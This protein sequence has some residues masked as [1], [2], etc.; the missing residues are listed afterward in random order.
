MK[1]AQPYL[2]AMAVEKRQY[3][4]KPLPEIA[5]AG[6]SNVG[7][8][9]FL[10]KFVGRKKL[11]YT[12]SSPGKTQ[13]VNFYNIDEK[14]R[15]VDLPG[16]G[17]A[18]AS[19]KAQEKWAESINEYLAI[20]EDLREVILLVDARHK[21]TNQDQQMYD[22]LVE[23]GFSGIVIASKADKV[24]RTKLPRHLKEIR[25][26]LDMLYPDLLFP[27]S[28]QTKEGLKEIHQI[29]EEILENA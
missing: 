21:P 6:R 15:L 14:F 10:N 1:I 28:A 16:Y 11:A 12:S 19:K 7:K 13:T 18:K 23:S 25:Q 22:W 4:R 8:S 17:Y 27:Y 20:R 26:S 9:T 24:P 29:F 3:P 2:E 5:L